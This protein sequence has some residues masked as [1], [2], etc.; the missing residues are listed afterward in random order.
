MLNL[1]LFVEQLNLVVSKVNSIDQDICDLLCAHLNAEVHVYSKPNSN[2]ISY[3]IVTDGAVLGHLNIHR[4]DL[5]K[6]EMLILHIAMAT[7]TIMLREKINYSKT[8]VR[9]LISS[10]SFSEL[11]A[12]TYIVKALDEAGKA[13]GLIN[14]GSIAEN[15]GFTRSIVTAA[16]KKLESSGLV[17]SRSLGMKGT[18]VRI[19]EPLLVKEIKKF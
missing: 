13:E 5:T 16:L 15:L 9:N 17:E 14:G 7:L 4:S 6:D 1:P 12:V 18:Y 19:K 2:G 11:I 8:A 3:P 10:L